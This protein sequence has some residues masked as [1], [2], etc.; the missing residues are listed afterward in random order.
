MNT[1]EK[2]NA[3]MTTNLKAAIAATS[4][5]EDAT[6]LINGKKV[7][8]GA[9][10]VFLRG[11]VNDVTVEAPP[12]LARELNLGLAEDG[13]L[14]IVASPIFGNWVVPVDGKFSWKI[15]PVAGKSGRI[16]LVFFSR[17]VLESWE[18]RSSVI[19]I[20][21][22][23][24]AVPLLN[25]IPIPESG[26]DLISGETKKITLAY[27]NGNHLQDVP[28]ALDWIPNR[29][30]QYQDLQSK[31]PLKELSSRHEWSIIDA[32][33][34]GTFKFK[35][36]NDSAQ[37]TL[38]TP[39][40]RL[41]PAYRLRYL[42][43]V[44]GEYVELPGP[45]VEIRVVTGFYFMLIRVRRPDNSPVVGVSVTFNV[46]GYTAQTRTTNS[47]GIA[48]QLYTLLPG[49]RECS[50]VMKLDGKEYVTKL[51]LIVSSPSENEVNK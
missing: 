38:L 50:A 9:K 29:G 27:K 35:I 21:L 8:W 42:M 28:L 17:E 2:G 7:E 13:D 19:S 10:P 20:D 11:Q 3:A 49:K 43:L 4:P 12:A 46:E 22:A 16:T 5:W 34:E 40:N 31:P 45:P 30:L 48:S 18:H 37:A 15:T 23:D 32:E 26:V 1:V 51:L 25:G 47:D 36:F 33:K 6:L 24:E 39:T 41:V 14:N 44:G